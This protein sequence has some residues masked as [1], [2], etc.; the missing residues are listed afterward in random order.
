VM[1]KSVHPTASCLPV[2]KARR[3][4][5]C[6]RHLDAPAL[7]SCERT[8]RA[9]RRT[10]LQV[11]CGRPSEGVIGDFVVSELR[12]FCHFPIRLIA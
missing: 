11:G 1:F 5:R 12:S 3:V 2:R 6:Q 8:P 10:T 9:M 7:L 4:Q